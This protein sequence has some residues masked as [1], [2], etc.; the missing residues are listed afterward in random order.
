MATFRNN[1]KKDWFSLETGPVFMH[2]D[3]LKDGSRNSATF[4]MELLG[5]TTNG[6]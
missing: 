5:L 6:Q 1:K 4:K 2:S 3:V